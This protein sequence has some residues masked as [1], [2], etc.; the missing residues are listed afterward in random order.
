MFLSMF[1]F[2]QDRRTNLEKERKRER[3][4]TDINVSSFQEICVFGKKTS[5]VSATR[6][7]ARMGR[8]YSACDLIMKYMCHTVYGTKFL[9]K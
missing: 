6:W 5:E 3:E 4:R 8:V 7:N 1:R 2:K 9:V